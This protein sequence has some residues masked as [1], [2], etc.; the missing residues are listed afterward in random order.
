MRVL[1]LEDSESRIK[2]FRSNI[3]SAIIVETAQECIDKLKEGDWELLFLDH[4]L[5][6][7]VYVDEQNT[8]TGSEV[9]RWIENNQPKIGKI[10]I[11]SLNH[12]AALNML[13]KLSGYDAEKIGYFN[14]DFEAFNVCA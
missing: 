12:D 13:S 1:I 14:I 5:G 10:I 2:R 9:A 4:D 6:G 8:N 3:P 7:E 11:H